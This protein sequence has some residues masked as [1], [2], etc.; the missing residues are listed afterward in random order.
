MQ[1]DSPESVRFIHTADWQLGATRWF[2]DDDA[3]ARWTASRFDAIRRI[4]QLAAEENCEFVVVAGDVFES[5]QVDRRTVLRACE[6]LEAIHVP[7]FLLPGNHDPLDAGTVFE[8][9]TWLSNKPEHVHVLSDPNTP[10]EVRPGVEVIGAPWFSKRPLG[11]LVADGFSSLTPQPDGVRV[12]VAHGATDELSPDRDNPALII[13]K[14]AEAALASGRAHYLALGD[15]HS[16]T[17]IGS[18]GRIWYSGTPEVYAFAE[19]D[20]GHAL[21]VNIDPIDCDVKPLDVGSWNFTRGEFDIQGEADINAVEEF[22]QAV[23]NKEQTVVRLALVGTVSLRDH[24]RLVEIV[25]RF[26]DLFAGVHE[27]G[28]RSDLVVVPKEEDFSDLSVSGFAAAA[29]EKLRAAADSGGPDGDKARDA[30]ALF[31][32]LAGTGQ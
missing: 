26:D 15:R 32:R 25:E 1:Q 6:A 17:D 29:V 18:S 22:L 31:V 12:M 7:V 10:H 5:N 3:R 2:L 24:A 23:E 21:L 27:S 11:D 13:V 20:P 16:V 8:S 28:S 14:Q 9:G 19:V 30:L 4:G